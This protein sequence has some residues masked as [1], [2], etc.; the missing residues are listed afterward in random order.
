MYIKKT[1]GST[2]NYLTQIGVPAAQLTQ[3]THKFI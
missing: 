3:I 1:Y 2:V